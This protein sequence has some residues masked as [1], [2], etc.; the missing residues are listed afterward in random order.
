MRKA[1]SDWMRIDLHIHTNMSK[2]TKDNDYK[3]TFTVSKLKEKLIEHRVDIFS[4]T[5]H[6]I[7]NVEAYKEY[8]SKSKLGDPLLLL[9]I[10]LD[11]VVSMLTGGERDYHSLLVFNLYSIDKVEELSCRLEE[12]YKN[13]G[14]IDKKKRKLTISEIAKLFPEDD[15]FFIP[16][17]GNTKSIKD[18]Y[19]GQIQNAQKMLLLMQSAFEKV[20]EKAIQN[21]N[22]GFNAVLNDSF[23]DRNDL[24][25]I[26][27]SDNH[28]IE[29]YP[30]VHTGDSG[31]DHSFFYV[32]G[33]KNFETLRL[34]FIDPESRIKSESQY[35]EIKKDN[36]S[37]YSLKIGPHKSMSEKELFF[38][39]HLNVIIGGRSSGKSLLLYVIGEKIDTIR[40]GKNDT[41]KDVINLSEV[42]IKSQLDHD[43]T[44]MTSI[45]SNL[46]YINQGD[47]VRY[48][49]EKKLEKLAAKS[50]KDAEYKASLILFSEHKDKV[51]KLVDALVDSYKLCH[52]AGSRQFVL[53]SATVK[54]IL[55]K[56]FIVALKDQDLIVKYD[57]DE[58]LSQSKLMI[59]TTISNLDLL[60]KD[61][62]IEFSEKEAE[63]IEEVTAILDNALIKVRGKQ[64]ST[65]KRLE[66]IS[67]VKGLISS[68]NDE[69]SEESK[70]KQQALIARDKLIGAM[71]DKFLLYR[72]LNQ[73]TEALETFDYSF[74]DKI[75]LSDD[76]SLV[77][78]VPKG[79][80]IKLQIMEGLNNSKPDQSLYINVMSL[81]K[82]RLTIKNLKGNA[83][84]DLNKKI[85]TQ[86]SH[87]YTSLEKPED[88]LEYNDHETSKN[89]SPGY[90]SEKYL[91]IVLQN[92]KTEKIFNDQPE[93]N[94]GNRFIA[95]KL[96]S[97]LRKIKFKKQIFIVTHNPSI[98]VYGDAESIVIAD[99]KNNVMTYKQIVLEDIKAQKEIC[100]ILDGGEYVFHKRALKYNIKRILT[101]DTAHA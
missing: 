20:P 11:I 37:I 39:P 62:H 50:S 17:A 77:L 1:F 8:Y 9:G 29:K 36:N 88:Y 4:L 46:V 12:A 15:F 53:H 6:N 5:D 86:L 84:S 52:E 80:D 3:G 16:H 45:G 60:L 44:D 10:E 90:N 82:N 98:V 100:Q 93:D 38:S 69:Q 95:D 89:K 87:I 74:T 43:Y 67:T 51:K 76:V 56:K 22:Q 71:S 14:I 30:C 41:Y 91:E 33:S 81:L 78:E 47:V 92:P 55:S 18:P 96:V 63:T 75:T 23:K 28:N 25:Y 54:H 26:D 99:N 13:K 7:I 19:E 73:A 49:E 59:E 24:A 97:I 42:K 101:E 64:D 72:K 27:F 48:F 58:N 83:P 66:I 61:A 32:K 31:I 85:Q 68:I 34:A 65:R 70:A 79:D 94:L 2:S 40:T 57:I 21:Y 35:E